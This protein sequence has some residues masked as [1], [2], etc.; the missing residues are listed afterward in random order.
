M[1]DRMTEYYTSVRDNPKAK[2]VSAI[3]NANPELLSILGL[4][5]EQPDQVN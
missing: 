3:E 2:A 4:G 1:D 5:D